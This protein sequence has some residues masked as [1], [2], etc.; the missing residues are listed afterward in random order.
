[1]VFLAPKRVNKL[2]IVLADTADELGIGYQL[3]LVAG[4]PS[5]FMNNDRLDSPTIR[6]AENRAFF[7]YLIQIFYLWL[8]LQYS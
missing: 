1:M 4:K 2:D 6:S 3:L 8:V 5:R 7:K